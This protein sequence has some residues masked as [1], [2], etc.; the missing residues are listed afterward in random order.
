MMRAAAPGWLP[1]QHSI[2]HSHACG[3]PKIE[4][5]TQF[6]RLTKIYSKYTLRKLKFAKPRLE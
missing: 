1:S 6:R 5:D 2:A 4:H 3:L